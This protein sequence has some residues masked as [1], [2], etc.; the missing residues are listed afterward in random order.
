MIHKTPG[1]AFCCHESF[2]N[3]F[4]N[5]LVSWSFKHKWA[6]TAIVSCFTFVSPVSS[7]MMAPAS[8]QIAT[9]F[10][11]TNSA[12]IAMMT[13]MFVMGYGVCGLVRWLL[14]RLSY[15]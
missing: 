3:P 14:L 13:T 2:I 4:P 1:S 15:W 11:V 9:Q 10:G 7:S 8:Q 12:I 6:A 5:D